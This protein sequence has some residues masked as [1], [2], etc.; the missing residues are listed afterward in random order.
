[1]PQNPFGVMRDQVI[2]MQ[3][4]FDDL[5]ERTKKD[6]DVVEAV[7]SLSRMRNALETLWARDINK[8]AR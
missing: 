7:N 2:E 8:R 5:D 1:M 6:R 4:W 3:K